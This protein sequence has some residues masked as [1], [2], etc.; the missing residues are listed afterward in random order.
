MKKIEEL[1]SK[2]SVDAIITIGGTGISKKDIT[3]EVISMKFNKKL[4]GF[5]ELFRYLSYADIGPSAMM[6]RAVAGIYKNKAIFCL[7]GSVDAINYAI[8]KLIVPELG[9]IIYEVNKK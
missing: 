2:K 8:S 1:S 3:T 4:E 5:G 9:H 7:P 6:S